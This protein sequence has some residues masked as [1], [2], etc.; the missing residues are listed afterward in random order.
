MLDRYFI[1]DK[2]VDD[3]YKITP[4]ELSSNGIRGLV[5]DIDNTLVTYDDEG[6]TP[7]VLEWFRTMEE[8]GIKIS[9]VSN[10][11]HQRVAGFNRELGYFA[12]GKSAKPFGKHIRR[13]MAH[14][15]T[16]K[17]TTALIGDQVFTDIMAGKCAGLRSYLVLPIK[18]KLT[19]FFRFKRMCEKPFLRKYKR[20]HSEDNK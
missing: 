12:Q 2:F 19:P 13:A 16:D 14:M 20:L 5:L 7:S 9:F 15:G 4:E 18:D 3:I 10:N 11:N 17:S 8:A 1:P 6:P